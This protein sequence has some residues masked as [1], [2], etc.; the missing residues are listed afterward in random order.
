MT[1]GA[2]LACRPFG[3]TAD[4]EHVLLYTLR[5]GRGGQACVATYGGIVT[6]LMAPDRDGRYDDVVLGFDE[7][8]GYL[9]SRA[10]F[11]A[12]IGRYA[13]RIANGRFTLAG[14]E[15]ALTRNDG[16]NS[17]HGG[18][19]GFDRA[20]WRVT[21]A[22]VGSTGPR[23]ALRH[24]SPDGDEGYPGALTAT[25]V[26]SLDD[27]GALRLDLEA[28]ADRPTYVNLTQ[29]SYFNLR[30][31][32]DVL[33]HRLCI[34]AQRFTPVRA[35]LIPTGELR[36]VAA[37]P[38][39]FRSPTAIGARIDAA[40]EQLALA[41]GYDHNFVIG[42]QDGRL[43]RHATA[44]DPYSGRLLEVLSTEPG[45][46]FYS[47]NFLDGSSVGK[48]GRRHDFRSGFC[49]EPQRFPDSPNQPAFPGAALEVGERYR[50]TI[51]Y[52]LTVPGEPKS[53]AARN[54]ADL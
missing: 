54:A 36:A 30:G 22:A 17:L 48:R 2:K 26:Y 46:Q 39:D 21:D 23:L 45:L 25:A 18:A 16:V 38:F 51:V 41:G 5:N 10:Y 42:A 52:R 34:S 29:H 11:G 50:H 14:R 53:A 35:D 33:D 12:L 28:T 49:L 47:G 32:G 9:S 15:Y 44:Y 40:D 24:V 6:K 43:L 20:V 27:A 19:R 31:R 8:A 3:T 1:D 37:T 13:N 4:G 7:L